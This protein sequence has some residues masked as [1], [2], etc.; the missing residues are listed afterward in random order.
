M[1]KKLTDTQ[2]VTLSTASAREDG[3]VLPMSKTAK[4]KGKTLDA[5]LNKLVQLDLIE[6][7][8]FNF[9]APSAVIA[10]RDG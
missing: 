2:L 7:H 3:S 5:V 6:E 4:A 1:T 10:R 8:C 9:N